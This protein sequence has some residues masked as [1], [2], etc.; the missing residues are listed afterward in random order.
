[1]GPKRQIGKTEAQD[2]HHHH[3]WN[4]WLTH[5]TLRTQR[6]SILM[7]CLHASNSLCNSNGSF[8]IPIQPTAE[9]NCRTDTTFSYLHFYKSTALANVR[10]SFQGI[11]IIHNFRNLQVAQVLLPP[12]QL[13]VCDLSAILWN[14]N[15]TKFGRAFQRNNAHTKFREYRSAK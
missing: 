3:V 10:I 6:A 14:L 9:E 4:C 12:H 7:L 15:V 13:A 11:I 1:V 2:S 8:V 5:T